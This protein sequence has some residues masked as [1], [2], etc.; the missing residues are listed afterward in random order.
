MKK[1]LILLL[2]LLMLSGCG[3][4][5]GTTPNTDSS[6]PSSNQTDDTQSNDSAASESSDG[7]A[8][9]FQL[10]FTAKD[11]DGNE[12]DQSVF[13]NA[14]LTMMNIWA[15]FC[16]PCINEMPELGEL[17][18]EGGTDY[19]IIGVCADLNG[20]EDMLED[21]KEIV[22]QTKANY[23]HLQPAEDLY[24]V[25]TASSSVPVTFFFDS[26]GKLVGKGILGAQDKDT[27]SQVISE[28]LEMVKADETTSAEDS[29]NDAA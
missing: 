14:K 9:T 23:L 2:A 1:S 29:T 21:A 8:E 11:L 27:W 10:T 13:A 26:E 6:A 5:A 18:A 16:G 20:T 25:L 19:Q 24:P 12:V 22:S 3:N 7:S 15:T 28:R 17:A 4:S